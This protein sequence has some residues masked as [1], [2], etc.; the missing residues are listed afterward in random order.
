MP[1]VQT[2]DNIRSGPVG[3]LP[4][5]QSYEQLFSSRHYYRELLQCSVPQMP[6][7]P[8]ASPASTSELY[9][10]QTPPSEAG[11]LTPKI[12]EGTPP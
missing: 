8:L 10:A 4:V 3:Q 6:F 2:V 7:G 5:P 1:L 11:V 12:G 9:T